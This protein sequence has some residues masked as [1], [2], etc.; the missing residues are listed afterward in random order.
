MEDLF[1]A[2][3]CDTDAEDGAAR[4][5]PKDKK[6]KKQ[7]SSKSTEADGSSD[8]SESSKQKKKGKKA[9]TYVTCPPVALIHMENP[10]IWWWC[11]MIQS[12]DIYII[13]ALGILILFFS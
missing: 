2:C 11:W 6:R 4:T 8:S 3:D 7:S 13:S 10:S 9:G 1:S 12:N 5:K